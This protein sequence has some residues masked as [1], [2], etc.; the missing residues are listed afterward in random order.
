MNE[1]QK[2][3]RLWRIVALLVLAFA[4]VGIPTAQAY[5]MWSCPSEFR[6]AVDQFKIDGGEAD[7]GDDLHLG[8]SPQGT[9]VACWDGDLQNANATR[10]VLR[11]NLYRDVLGGDLSPNRICAH[12]GIRFFSADGVVRATPNV[13]E[14]CANAGTGGLI[15]R[16]VNVTVATPVTMIRLDLS[17]RYTD[18]LGNPQ[19]STLT[20]TKNVRFH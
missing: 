19:G 10:V 17:V 14:A 12:A 16:E 8:G 11:G 15:S 3:T 18:S 9:A 5:D 7:F 2:V 1:A 6:D 13:P 4:A 20:K